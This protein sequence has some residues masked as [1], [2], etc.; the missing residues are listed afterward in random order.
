MRLAPVAAAGAC[1]LSLLLV[2]DIAR[3]DCSSLLSAINTLKAN[4]PREPRDAA[5]DDRQVLENYVGVYNRACTGSGP[6]RGSGPSYRGGSPG[7]NAANALGAAANALGALGDLLDEM[8]RENQEEAAREAERQQELEDE[9]QQEEIEQAQQAAAQRAAAAQARAAQAALDAQQRQALANP[10]GGS[11][12][13]SSSGGGNPFDTPKGKGSSNPFATTASAA[14]PPA[15]TKITPAPAPKSTSGSSQG[16]G[17]KTDA[18]IKSECANASNPGVCTL[19]ETNARNA[20]PAYKKYAAQQKKEMKQKVDAEQKKVD[21]AFKDFDNRKAQRKPPETLGSLPAILAGL[22]VP[23]DDGLEC[24]PG[25]HGRRRAGQCFMPDVSPGDCAAIGGNFYPGDDDHP[26]PFCATSAPANPMTAHPG[27]HEGEQCGD[28]AGHIHGGACW[29]LGITRDDC[30]NELHGITM[31]NGGFQ[32][33]AYDAAQLDAERD[34]AA[35]AAASKRKVSKLRDDLRKRMEGQDPDDADDGDDTAGPTTPPVPPK[36]PVVPVVVKQDG[37][38]AAEK[39]PWK[40]DY[41]CRLFDGTVLHTDDPTQISGYEIT[42]PPDCHLM[43]SP[44]IVGLTG[45]SDGK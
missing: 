4:I 11:G 20:S 41:E 18:Q 32:Y 9:Q 35:K 34:A 23:N 36:P 7:N 5:N 12:G 8:D 30:A 24:G 38:P 16:G 44:P 31:D 43:N 45:Q 17:F 25:G 22:P 14:P 10:F 2:P 26:T 6:S 40:P 39:A 15:A 3:A 13:S 33:C 19:M 37:P 29:A 27:P 28:V 42:H 21:Q 1:L